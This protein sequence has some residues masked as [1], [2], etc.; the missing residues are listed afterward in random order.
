M[1]DK[2]PRGG[3]GRGQGRHPKDP[4]HLWLRYIIRLPPEWKDDLKAE[5]GTLQAAI[6]ALVIDH[7]KA[8]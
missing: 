4:S 3:A 6:E 8:K 7:R 2:K 1:T 5:Y